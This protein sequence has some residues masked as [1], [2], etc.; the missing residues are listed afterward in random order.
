MVVVV[1]WYCGSDTR[2]ESS[3]SSSSS[4]SW[5]N[6]SGIANGVYDDSRLLVCLFVS[7]LHAEVQQLSF[8][9]KRYRVSVPVLAPVHTPVLTVQASAGDPGLQLSYS[10]LLINNR[11]PGSRSLF[12]IDGDSG[13]SLFGKRS[14]GVT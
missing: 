12:N 9:K 14:R 2:S 10:V 6:V 8:T 5:Y 1:W 7:P 11:T 3:S 13:K 4:S